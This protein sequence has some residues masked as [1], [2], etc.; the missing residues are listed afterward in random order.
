MD[1]YQG[2]VALARQKI[3]SDYEKLKSQ[4]PGTEP[5]SYFEGWCRNNLHNVGEAFRSEVWRGFLNSLYEHRK[6]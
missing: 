4:C 6:R 2:A 3:Y 1:S 5:E